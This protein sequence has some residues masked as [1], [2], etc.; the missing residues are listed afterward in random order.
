MKHYLQVVLFGNYLIGYKTVLP[1]HDCL[2]L[3]NSKFVCCKIYSY[4][5]VAFSFGTPSFAP[6]AM[7]WLCSLIFFSCN[8]S[9]GTHVLQFCVPKSK[10]MWILHIDISCNITTNTK[11]KLIKS[12]KNKCVQVI[13]TSI[14]WKPFLNVHLF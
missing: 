13:F 4:S 9:S 3:T 12:I 11:R 2:S 1:T 8:F 14:F 7:L 6:S 5:Q 10:E